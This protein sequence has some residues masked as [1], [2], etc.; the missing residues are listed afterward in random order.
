VSHAAQHWRVWMR[1]ATWGAASCVLAVLCCE[2][3]SAHANEPSAPAIPPHGIRAAAWAVELQATD[4]MPIAGGLGPRTTTGQDGKL[5]AV[6]TVLRDSA[7][8]TVA[9]VSVDILMIGRS[10][11]DAAASEIERK[12]GIPFEHVLISCTHTHHAPATVKVHGCDVHEPFA[13]HVQEAI[14]RAVEGA[15]RRLPQSGECRVRFAMA[16]EKTVGQNSRL[17]LSDGTIYWVGSRDDA[18][19]PT[20][21]V[22]PQLP[23]IV[24]ERST[25][26]RLEALIFGHST[27]TIGT[28]NIGH[29]SPGFYGLAAQDLESELGGTVL[30]LQG[31]SGSTHLLGLDDLPFPQAWVEAERRIRTVVRQAYDR[32]NTLPVHRIA[33]AKREI[34]VRVRQFDEQQEE[35]A[36]SRYC[37]K[38]IDREPERYIANFRQM[39]REIAPYQGQ[40]RKTWIQAVAIGEIAIVGVPAELFTV[41]GLEIKRRS[42]FKHTIIAELAN[43]HIGYVG[44]EPSYGLGG[45]QLW[46]GHHSW[47]E[48]GTGEL[49]V[50]ECV[51]LLAAVYGMNAE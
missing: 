12:T 47:T 35:E 45:Y 37:L 21:P 49:I 30:F 24:V 14:V 8:S 11:L 18:L 25:D 7:G 22:D 19:R 3:C 1:F 43:D 34:A 6:A 16:E 51:D 40:E 29:R 13:S 5:R 48:A 20:G 42:P 9:F 4:E 28:R 31:A 33:S 15:V 2:L 27:H 39:R 32:A 41:L 38:R 10:Y 46:T 50:Q 23:V 36:V 26:G 17:L 44:D